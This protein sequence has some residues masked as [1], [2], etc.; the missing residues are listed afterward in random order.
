MGYDEEEVFMEG[1]IEKFQEIKDE[2]K[3]FVMRELDRW[4][5]QERKKEKPKNESEDEEEEKAITSVFE[6]LAGTENELTRTD[7]RR[8]LKLGFDR[9]E[10]IVDGFVKEYKSI[11]EKDDKE[12]HKALY[13]H[14][15]KRGII[16]N[17]EE[18][19]TDD[20]DE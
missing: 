16:R 18:D 17:L 11:Q 15:T 14:L 13:S 5:I 9:Y 2:L 7:I 19:D 20:T 4:L 12:V 10:I 3:T 6:H 8:I 1:F